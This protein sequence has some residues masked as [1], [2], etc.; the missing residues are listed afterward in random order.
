MSRSPSGGPESLAHASP[1]NTSMEKQDG[2]GN[3]MVDADPSQG[4]R[5][6]SQTL[7]QWT[8]GV[9]GDPGG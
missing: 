7:P 8:Q 4:P 1:F 2:A 9:G 6:P 3:S 5:L